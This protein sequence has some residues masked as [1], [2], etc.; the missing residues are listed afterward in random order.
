MIATKAN[1]ILMFA[2]ITAALIKWGINFWTVGVAVIAIIIQSASSAA[3][4][5]YEA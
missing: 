4:A 3:V 5:K 2:W 1:W